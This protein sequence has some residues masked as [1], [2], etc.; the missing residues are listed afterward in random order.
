MDTIFEFIRRTFK[1]GKVTVNPNKDLEK[2][3]ERDNEFIN[4]DLENLQDCSDDFINEELRKLSE[5]EATGSL[6]PSEEEREDLLLYERMS[7][8]FT[9]EEAKK[10]ATKREQ[11]A[12]NFRKKV[13]ET[14]SPF[15]ENQWV[16]LKTSSLPRIPDGSEGVILDVLSPDFDLYIEKDIVRYKY[17]LEVH[18]E[19]PETSQIIGSAVWTVDEDQLEATAEKNWI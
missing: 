16:R 12:A 3:Q 2:L 1:K 14:P 18:A 9:T 10:K 4:Q 17:L 6:K 19:D 5:I 7:R 8:N 15:K 11:Y 13:T